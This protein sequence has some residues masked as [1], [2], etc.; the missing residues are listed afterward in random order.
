M[1]GAGTGMAVG[2]ASTS[3]VPQLPRDGRGGG[4]HA[5]PVTPFTSWKPVALASSS[6]AAGAWLS[7]EKP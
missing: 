4:T 3:D 5:A 2:T 1:I 7:Q 6:C